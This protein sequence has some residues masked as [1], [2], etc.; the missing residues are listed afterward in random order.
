MILFFV[1][2]L[3]TPEVTI[4]FEAVTFSVDEGNGT[5]TVNLARRT[6]IL[7]DNIT[8]F[9]NVTML[10]DPAIIQRMYEYIAY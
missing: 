1:C 2:S 5:V 4:E 7:S 8:V 10:V 9:I 6:G 3:V